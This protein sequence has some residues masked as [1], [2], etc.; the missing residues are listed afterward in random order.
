MG[1][2]VYFKGASLKQILTFSAGNHVRDCYDA[3]RAVMAQE[4]P[5]DLVMRVTRSLQAWN[6]TGEMNPALEEK[7]KR[8]PFVAR[9]SATA[10]TPPVI[11]GWLRRMIYGP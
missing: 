7:L 11:A 1:Y 4:S 6:L 8:M 10:M 5:N 2:S 9:I 3:V